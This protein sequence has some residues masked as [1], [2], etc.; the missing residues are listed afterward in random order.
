MYELFAAVCMSTPTHEYSCGRRKPHFTDIITMP[1]NLHVS[2]AASISDAAKE[3]LQP[4]AALSSP[5]HIE[6]QA[7]SAP[8]TASILIVDDRPENLLALEAILD[9]PGID[10]VRA[11]SGPEALR[12][13]L[14]QDFA[15]IL[16]DVQMPGMDG[17]QTI[18]KLRLMDSAAT[19]PI[20]VFTALAD[21][22]TRRRARDVGADA[23]L[24]KPVMPQELISRLSEML[25][26]AV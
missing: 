21:D 7:P 3:S 8:T 5:S 10:L 12:H 9:A 15:V 25:R 22:Q 2:P 11:A 4:F 14:R 20:L 16:M 23:I 26:S 1:V 18:Q 17:F 19:T 13:V 24:Q 6:E